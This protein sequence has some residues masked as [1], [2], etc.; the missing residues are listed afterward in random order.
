VKVGAIVQA[1]FSSTRLPG[2]VLKEVPA[3]SGITVLEHVTRRLKKSKRLDE[4]IV[5]TVNKKDRDEIANVAKKEKVTLFRGSEENV[6]SRYYFCAKENELDVIVRICSDCPCIDPEIV[7][8]I[9]TRHIKS[10]SDYTSNTLTRSYPR[11]FDT[12]VFNFSV[13]EKAYKNAKKPSEKEHVTPYIYKRPK[14][15]KI[16]QVKAPRELYGPDIRLVLDT[17]EDYSFIN[18]IFSL[19]FKKKAKFTAFDVVKTLR[20]NPWLKSLNNKVIQKK[21]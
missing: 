11:G 3:G 14:A 5:A 7:D 9:I 17:K 18:A 21:I 12:E 6:L 19:L 20:E 15:F 10:K 16:T 4:I 2:K 8:S 1:R 13:L